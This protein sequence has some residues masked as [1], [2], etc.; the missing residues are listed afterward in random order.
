MLSY[1]TDGVKIGREGQRW[2]QESH[3]QDCLDQGSSN[4]GEETHLQSDHIIKAE[5]PGITSSLS[6]KFLGAFARTL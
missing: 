1:A 2:L 4:G 5:L 6:G 3:K